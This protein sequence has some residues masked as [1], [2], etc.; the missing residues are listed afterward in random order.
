[1]IYVSENAVKSNLKKYGYKIYDDKTVQLINDALTCFS[2]NALRKI[3][4]KYSAAKKGGDVQEGG[5]VILPSEYFGVDSGKYADTVAAVDMSVT[6]ELI[7]PALLVDDPT[8][9]IMQGG[10]SKFSISSTAFKSCVNE[11]MSSLKLHDLTMSSKALKALQ[12]NYETL[13]DGALK[14]TSK[15]YKSNELSSHNLETVLKMN[16]YSLL[17]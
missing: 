9:A 15:E 5:R 8:G 4:K 10:A 13:M 11:Q 16:K 7:R 2:T 12:N 14:K 17:R 3:S 6:S 1:M